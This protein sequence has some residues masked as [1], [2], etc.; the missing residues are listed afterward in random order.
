MLFNLGMTADAAAAHNSDLV[1]SKSDIHSSLPSRQSSSSRPFSFGTL[2]VCGLGNLYSK[3]KIPDP[4]IPR[5]E[6]RYSMPLTALERL[7][8]SD[9]DRYSHTGP[10]PARPQFSYQKSSRPPAVRSKTTYQLAHPAINARQARLR[11][12]PKLLLQ[13]QRV[14]PTS[15]PV[16]VYDVVPSTVFKNR[17]A[18]KVPAILRGKKGLGP[19]DLIV[20]TSDLYERTGIDPTERSLS[21]DDENGDHREVVAT[22]CQLFK[23]DALSKGKA[24]ICLNTGSVWEATPLPNGSY[25]FAANTDAGILIVRWVRRGQKKRRVSAPPGSLEQEDTKRFTF[26]VINPNTRRH[27][28]IACMTRNHLEVHDRYAMPPNSTAPSSPTAMSV[29]SDAS[30]LDAPLDQNLIETDENTRLL[31]IMTSIWVA[32]RE[33]WSL[34]FRY[35]DSN[36]KPTPKTSKPASTTDGDSVPGGKDHKPGPE[37]TTNANRRVT[38]SSAL[39]TQQPTVERSIRYGSLSKRSN[40]T[41][42]AFI[43]RSN[44]RT[45]GVNGR[46]HRHSMFSSPRPSFDE[47]SDSVSVARSSGCCRSRSQ[48]V[49]ADAED[50]KDDLPPTRVPIH[51]EETPASQPRQL[52]TS[53]PPDDQ[54]GSGR[55][56]GKRRHRFSN[57]FDFFVRRG[58]HHQS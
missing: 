48:H 39:P 51:P 58:H 50:M 5:L 23:E 47:A 6:Q 29:I 24:E 26:S 17:L 16:P 30:E 49:R 55:T 28:V 37:V 13:L 46:P 32:F 21:S 42:A 54:V 15:R 40:S 56:K 43:E 44:R 36:C 38:I 25:E 27:P 1:A 19:N 57:L 20:T 9:D 18:R 11:L 8:S 31:I 12:R 33:G 34:N 4:E 41:G 35:N 45:S 52:E 7:S 53:Q 2:P 14:S 10:L 3:D 22:I